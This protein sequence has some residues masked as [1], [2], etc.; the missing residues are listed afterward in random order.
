MT[1]SKFFFIYIWL[2]LFGILLSLY[3][4][5]IFKICIAL[6]GFI[7]GF[8]IF[9][10]ITFFIC[11]KELISIIIGIIV[12]LI[13]GI[14]LLFL[15]FTS[16]ISSGAILGFFIAY[17][18]LPKM[19][20]ILLIIFYIIFIITGAIFAFFLQKGVLIVSS[21]FIGAYF[22]SLSIIMLFGIITPQNIKEL[23][24][25]NNL[26]SLNTKLIVITLTLILGLFSLFYQFKTIKE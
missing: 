9:Y 2:L 16:I 23:L 24:E 8:I 1:I 25:I 7:T 4:Y 15:Y 17:N 10:K 13:I 5:K 11:Q 26:L 3:G 21:A 14:I 18:I 12:G 19:D 22:I 6:L 20:N